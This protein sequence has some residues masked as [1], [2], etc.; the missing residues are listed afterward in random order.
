[1]CSAPNVYMFVYT[2]IGAHIVPLIPCGVI[3]TPEDHFHALHKNHQ[4]HSSEVSWLCQAIC[5]NFI[6]DNVLQFHARMAL[7]LRPARGAG[8]SC[9]V[10]CPSLRQ[11]WSTLLV[12]LFFHVNLLC[13][14]KRFE[15]I[16]HLHSHGWHGTQ[17]PI[18]VLHPA[19]YYRA[20]KA[21]SGSCQS[22]GDYTFPGTMPPRIPVPDPSGSAGE[23]QT[24][25]W[26]DTRGRRP[27]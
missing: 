18:K 26:T 16:N 20:S 24:V 9:Y 25:T 10:F 8:G 23:S 17:G 6:S 7:I 3:F 14:Y 2:L 1:M 4:H 21:W 12:L 27:P 22:A 15:I 13:M 11:R 5:C 19:R